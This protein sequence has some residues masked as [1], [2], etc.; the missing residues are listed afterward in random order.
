VSSE[1]TPSD[2]DDE[3]FNKAEVRFSAKL[4]RRPQ[5][6]R[7][8]A[9]IGNWAVGLFAGEPET[10]FPV[11]DRVVVTDSRTNRIVLK[12]AADPE[13]VPDGLLTEISAD[14]KALSIRQFRTKWDIPD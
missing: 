5:V 2:P 13:I 7:T 10:P 11:E 6:L 9:W 4:A 12:R 3:I 8:A 1:A 14:L